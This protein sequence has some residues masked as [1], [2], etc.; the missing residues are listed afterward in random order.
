MSV[1][2]NILSPE[3]TNS[4]AVPVL[5]NQG[6]VAGGHVQSSAGTVA[7]AAASLGA[8]SANPFVLASQSTYRV[9]PGIPSGVRLTSCKLVF[10]ALTTMQVDI[11]VFLPGT[12]TPVPGAGVTFGSGSAGI[13]LL[14][15]IAAPQSC[16]AAGV[17]LTTA[18]PVW[19]EYLGSG[20]AAVQALYGDKSLWELAGFATDPNVIWDIGLTCVVTGTGAAGELAM[21]IE[22]IR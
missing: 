22:Y 20:N 4:V 15:N 11:G 21:Q 18:Q 7:I 13:T 3:V 5:A 17:L 8:A 1:N 10:S 12:N 2:E 16:I 6:R 14:G 19:T 9:I